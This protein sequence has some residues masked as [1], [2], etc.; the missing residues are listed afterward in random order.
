MALAADLLFTEV[1]SNRNL[2]RKCLG[3]AKNY[4]TNAIKKD[5]TKVNYP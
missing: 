4:F 1:I 2:K 3:I 5:P